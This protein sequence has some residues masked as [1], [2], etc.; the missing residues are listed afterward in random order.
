MGEEGIRT[1]AKTML[2]ATVY[3]KL[4]EIANMEERASS[5]AQHGC[6]DSNDEAK[7]I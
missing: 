3:V 1:A 6:S 2:E 7:R 5:I 4:T